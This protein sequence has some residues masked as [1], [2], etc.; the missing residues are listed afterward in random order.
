MTTKPGLRE[1]KKERTRQALVTAA[2]ELFGT[3]GYE[4]TTIAE[5]A[6]AADISTR[7]FFSYFASKEEVLFEG[8]PLKLERSA[9]VLA[10]RLPGEQPAELLLRSFHFVLDQDTD[11]TGDLAKLRTRLILQTPALQPYALRKVLEGQR[12][13]AQGLITAYRGEIDPVVAVAMT[14]ALVGAL[15]STIATLLGRSEQEGGTPAD[16]EQLQ[17]EME[18]AVR[19][20][21]GA[22]GTLA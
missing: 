13:L 10:E 17:A 21:L 16:P 8:T 6:E 11:L 2:I 12:E 22:F 4:E 1:R 5:L 20:A 15:V 3:K 7:T 9:S 19:S 18:H 14:G